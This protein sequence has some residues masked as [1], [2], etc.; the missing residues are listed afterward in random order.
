MEKESDRKQ[1]VRDSLTVDKTGQDDP[2]ESRS[3]RYRK[4]VDALRD[5]MFE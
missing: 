2:A 3:E 5:C 4:K 1:R